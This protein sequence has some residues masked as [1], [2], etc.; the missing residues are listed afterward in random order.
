[1]ESNLRVFFS[2]LV[3]TSFGLFL[4]TNVDLTGGGCN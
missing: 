2:L 4:V 3:L 1:M